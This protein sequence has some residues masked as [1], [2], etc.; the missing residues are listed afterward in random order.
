MRLR[1]LDV[2]TRWFWFVIFAQRVY[3]KPRIEALLYPPNRWGGSWFHVWRREP[4]PDERG[5]EVPNEVPA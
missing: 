5:A 2:N 1:V 3:G 4:F